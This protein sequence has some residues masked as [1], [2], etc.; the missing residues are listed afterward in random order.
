MLNFDDRIIYSF[1]KNIFLTTLLASQYSDKMKK[2]KPGRPGRVN[3]KKFRHYLLRCQSFARAA[4]RF[5]ISRQRA[6]QLGAELGLALQIGPKGMPSPSVKQGFHSQANALQ[7]PQTS[8][9]D[10]V[11]A[12][13]PAGS[14]ASDRADT[15]GGEPPTTSQEEGR[16]SRQGP[17]AETAKPHGFVR[18]E[19]EENRRRAQHLANVIE[20]LF[21]EENDTLMRD[22]IA[23]FLRA[24]ASEYQGAAYEGMMNVADRISGR[25]QSADERTRSVGAIQ[26]IVGQDE[27]QVKRLGSAIKKVLQSDPDE[28]RSELQVRDRLL[29][30]DF[31][32][33]RTIPRTWVQSVLIELAKLRLVE[34]RKDTK[35]G[36]D[37]YR[38]KEPAE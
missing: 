28:W 16:N 15:S 7:A 19:Q 2:K 22:A 5:K 25:V 37:E 1:V 10:Q 11:T 33:Y 35:A 18:E 26:S 34:V 20:V 13:S 38:W 12:L 32:D 3:K 24:R 17:A 9:Q 31:S 30:P 27:K 29:A 21:G 36:V 6:Q 4:R 14:G 8:I 23:M